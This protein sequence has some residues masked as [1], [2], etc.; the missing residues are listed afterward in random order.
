[1]TEHTAPFL[2]GVW[3]RLPILTLVGAILGGCLAVVL[4]YPL[5]G[6][7]V[8]S[9]V[10]LFAVDAAVAGRMEWL[11]TQS[12]VSLARDLSR[13]ARLDMVWALPFVLLVNAIAIGA[14]YWRRWRIPAVSLVVVLLVVGTPIAFLTVEVLIPGAIWKGAYDPG[15]WIPRWGVFTWERMFAC[16]AGL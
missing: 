2:L 14:C 5:V 1:M 7:L 8:L 16:P 15:P 12:A 13:S 4:C 10:W 3:L 9:V 6:F 11:W